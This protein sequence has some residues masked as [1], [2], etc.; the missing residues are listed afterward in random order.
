MP[1]FCIISCMRKQQLLDKLEQAWSDFETS[2]AGLSDEQ[3]LTP[4]VTGNWSVKDLLAHVTWWEE[5][6]LK[7]LPD[8]LAGIRPPRYSD[9]Y[10]GIDEF[11]AH[12]TEQKRRLSL[13]E[14]RQQHAA[15][16]RRLVAFLE[17]A[18]EEQFTTET[19]F[20]R[21]IRLDTYSH[22]P[23]HARAIREWRSTVLA[24]ES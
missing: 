13:Q 7:H 17:S 8:I 2:Y 24:P 10:G 23:I 16:H 21:R 20:R 1:D 12:M 18:P 4:G 6:S 11:N 5:E 15:T 22:Y 19:N 9:V 3:M 14:V